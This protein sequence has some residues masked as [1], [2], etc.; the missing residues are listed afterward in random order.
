ME[1]PTD[2]AWEA[3]GVF[4]DQGRAIRAVFI[5]QGNLSDF[6]FAKGVNERVHR[7]A[8]IQAN[9]VVS[10]PAEE[11]GCVHGRAAFIV[12]SNRVRMG[13]LPTLRTGS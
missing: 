9:V 2:D 10:H 8:Q 4:G 6:T 7:T 13:R 1:R 11:F 3:Q 5:I 12:P